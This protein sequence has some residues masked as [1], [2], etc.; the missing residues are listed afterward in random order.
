M[1]AREHLR[2]M[3]LF[4][5]VR[6][7]TTHEKQALSGWAGSSCASI[8]SHSKIC[9]LA[10]MRTRDIRMLLASVEKIPRNPAT[11]DNQRRADLKYF[12]V[13]NRP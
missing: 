3:M 5:D 8:F 2:A 7:R 1:E 13:S 12:G 11:R 9:I 10:A 6:R 4:D